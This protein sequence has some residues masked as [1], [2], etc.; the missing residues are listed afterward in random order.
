MA[1][2]D[3][4]RTRYRLVFFAHPDPGTSGYRIYDDRD[5]EV[6]PINEF[7]D[8]VAVRGLSEKTTRAYAFD[9]L[10]F[11][12][13]FSRTGVELPKLTEDTLLT[14]VRSQYEGDPKPAPASINHRLM[15][16]RSF[17]QHAT[18]K[19]LAS[20]RHRPQGRGHP[21]ERGPCASIGYLGRTRQRPHAFWVKMERRVI[22]PLA[23]EE[24]TAFLASFR[25]WRDLGLVG[26]ML[27]S[28]LRTREILH[29][30]LEDLSIPQGQI[31]VRGKGKKE[32][33]VPLS[34]EVAS[35]LK[36]YLDQERPNSPS[37]RF[38]LCLKGPRRGHPMT[39]A[40]IRSLFRYH[41]TTSGI[42]KANPHRMRH[43]FGA[44]MARAG[45]SIPSLQ[46]LM[47]HA[48][49]RTTMLYVS[50]SLQDVWDE[51]R[52]AA[53]KIRDQRERKN[54]PK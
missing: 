52:R 50:L 25:T 35:I 23:P 21:Y 51:Y 38:F 24:V 41:R 30:T 54:S 8:F 11:W 37:D 44:N 39:A 29:L 40:G 32:R 31:L 12:R 15:V 1:R 45:M 13:W 43:T 49:F 7:L 17:Y 18:G 47:G 10:H 53:A 16:V 4:R 28:G 34:P 46:R 42:A 36:A 6:Q 48:D 3:K 22:L 9:L 2:S 5:Q 26:L 33:I 20:G 14:Y 19:P 27:S